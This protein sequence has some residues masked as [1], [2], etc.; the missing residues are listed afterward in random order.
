MIKCCTYSSCKSREW[1]NSA[2]TQHHRQRKINLT[3]SLSIFIFFSLLILKSWK[4]PSTVTTN[5]VWQSLPLPLLKLESHYSFLLTEQCQLAM[6][7]KI[8]LPSAYIKKLFGLIFSSVLFKKLGGIC[9]VKYTL[10]LNS[11]KL[12]L[13]LSISNIIREERNSRFHIWKSLSKKSYLLRNSKTLNF[14]FLH[15]V[16]WILEYK[17]WLD[18]TSAIY[19]FC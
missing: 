16:V 11:G 15:K 5:I 4:E 3:L 18:Y 6:H 2:C 19:T 14:D 1:S 12:F 10:F 7:I 17:I 9:K 8:G 13:F